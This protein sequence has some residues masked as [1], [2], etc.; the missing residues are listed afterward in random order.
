MNATGSVTFGGVGFAAVLADITTE[1][2]H[3]YHFKGYIG[4]IGTP[5]VGYGTQFSGDFPGLERILG[6]CA[7]EVSTASMGPGFA[8]LT[9]FDLHGQI[10]T[11]V[12][13]VFGGGFDVGMGG[14]TWDDEEFKVKKPAEPETPTPTA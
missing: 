6:Q 10:G 7:L 14:G 9:W 2:G 5:Q 11:L 8:Q 4:E 1:D 3:K 13:Q 12:G